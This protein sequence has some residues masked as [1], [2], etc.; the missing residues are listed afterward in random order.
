MNLTL[1]VFRLVVG[2]LFV[3]HGS[4]KLF[5]AFGG[6]GLDGTAATFEQVGLRP[7]H[8]HATAA[9]LAE[10]GG[11]LLIALGLLVPLGAAALIGTMVAA[12]VTVH[13]RNG[14]WVTRNGFEYNLVLAAGAFLLSGVGPGLWSLDHALGLSLSGTGWALGALVAGLLGGA[15]AVIGGRLY[16]ET[17]RHQNPHHPHPV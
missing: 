15:A 11:G 9:G 3:G 17:H 13:A 16:E 4:Q 5:G 8:T 12:I 2:L 14:I 7:G 10:A 1:L 6:Q